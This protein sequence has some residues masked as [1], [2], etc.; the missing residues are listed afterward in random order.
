MAGRGEFGREA[1]ELDHVAASLFGEQHQETAVGRLAAPARIGRR[2]ERAGPVEARRGETRFE[3]RPSFAPFAVQ[4]LHERCMVAR[5][6]VVRRE[7]E[8]AG[9]IGE[10]F[11]E[12]AESIEQIA[13]VGEGGRKIGRA[14]ESCVEVGQRVGVP[15]GQHQRGRTR[16]ARESLVGTQRDCAPEALESVLAASKCRQNMRAVDPGFGEIRVQPRSHDRTG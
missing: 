9:K 7:R 5:V 12:P 14:C 2:D 4:Q 16:V 3:F 13:A 6:V 15:I 11:V 10:R 1:R 8:R